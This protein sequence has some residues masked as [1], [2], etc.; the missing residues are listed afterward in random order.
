V[1]ARNR[2][3]AK[4]VARGQFRSDLYYPLNVFPIFL[5]ALQE[6]GRHSCS[7]GLSLRKEPA[8]PQLHNEDSPDLRVELA[9]THGIKL[10]VGKREGLERQT[11]MDR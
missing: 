4:M 8:F 1:A 7:H 9:A 11:P 3:L 10:E 6:P 2:N 5:P